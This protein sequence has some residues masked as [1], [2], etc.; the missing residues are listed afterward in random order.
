[1]S[2][3]YRVKMAS[4]LPGALCWQ[5]GNHFPISQPPLRCCAILPNVQLDQMV[6]V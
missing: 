1:M 6:T 4:K 5:I 3:N 2:M